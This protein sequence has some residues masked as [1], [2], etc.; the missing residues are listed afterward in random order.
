M[1]RRLFSIGWAAVLAGI[2]LPLRAAS[3]RPILDAADRALS[4]AFPSTSGEWRWELLGPAPVVPAEVVDVAAE[5]DPV[6]PT[7]RALVSLTVRLTRNGRRVRTVLLSYRLHRT[8][9]VWVTRRSVAA[10]A[11]VSI[12]D[13]IQVRREISPAERLLAPA[14]TPDHLWARRLP[15]GTPLAASMVVP[16]PLVKNGETVRVTVTAGTLRLSAT[17]RALRDG[18]SGD[19]IPVWLASTRRPVTATV[20]GPGQLDLTAPGAAQ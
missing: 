12:D 10:G 11:P 8:A 17:G 4:R 18:R 20:R 9:A 5:A 3:V 16:R 1:G 13:L 7:P 15:V 6:D 19:A 2:C 14:D